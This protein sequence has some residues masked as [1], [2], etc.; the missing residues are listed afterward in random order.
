M[1]INII[2]GLFII[3]I[4]S[5]CQSSCYVPINKIKEWS[6]ESYWLVQ[7]FFAWL[8]F[9][10]LGTIA[11]IPEGNSISELLLQTDTFHLL[12]TIHDWSSCHAHRHSHYWYCRSYASSNPRSR[13]IEGQ[14]K[15]KQF[16]QR[17]HHCFAMRLYEWL[18]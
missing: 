6:W 15:G 3:A 8:V 12:M 13:D 14:Q 10:F 17:Y 5:F 11:A 7:V 18:F 4:G 16:L 9:P 1:D 2:I